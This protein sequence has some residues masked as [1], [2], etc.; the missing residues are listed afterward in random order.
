MTHLDASA[1]PSRKR[2]PERDAVATRGRILSV[3]TRLFAR[4]GFEGATTDQIADKAQVNKRMIYHYFGSKEQLYLAVLERAYA[5]ARE[6]EARLKLDEAAPVSALARLAE[7]TFDSFARDRTFISLLNTEN[8]NEGKVLK[9]SAKVREM[10]STVVTA[11]ARILAKGETEGLFRK[12]IDPFQLWVSIVGV[13]YFY[14]SNIHTL[15]IVGGSKLTEAA[16][17]AER[18]RHVVD[19]VLN[20]VRP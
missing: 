11:V 10:N 14:F 16:A 12:G 13:S 5:T 3:A 17:L 2:G 4:R 8:R 6:A 18:R 7:F 15:S 1:P 20:G 19:F 9:K